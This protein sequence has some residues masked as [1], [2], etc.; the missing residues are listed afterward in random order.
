MI[1]HLRISNLMGFEAFENPV[2][3]PSITV[4]LGKNDTCKTALLKMLYTVGKSAELY[5]KQRVHSPAVSFKGILSSK[6]SA[7]Y[8]TKQSGLGDVVRKNGLPKKLSVGAVCEGQITKVGFS[9][10]ADTRTSITDVCLE[11]NEE[12]RISNY[13]FIP[14]KEVITAFNAIKAIA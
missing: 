14:A 7:I 5:A 8:G 2:P 9:F 11:T 3:F 6:M 1:R 4:V 10:G 12:G 13:V